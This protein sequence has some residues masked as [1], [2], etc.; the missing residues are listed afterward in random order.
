[1]ERERNPAKPVFC[2]AFC[3]GMGVAEADMSLCMR[4]CRPLT[5]A[6]KAAQMIKKK[7]DMEPMKNALVAF[8]F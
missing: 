2:A 7:L 6:Q 5:G 4:N 1:M 8:F 3:C